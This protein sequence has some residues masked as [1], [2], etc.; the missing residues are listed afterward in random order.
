MEGKVCNKCGEWKPLEEYYNRKASKDGKASRCKKCQ[1]KDKIQYNKNN[2]EKVK[3]SKKRWK[4][5]NK[6]YQKQYRENNKEEIKKTKKQHYENNKNKIREM[7]K[8]YYESN[9]DK[10]KEKRKEY[11]KN[12]K[13]KEKERNKQYRI[14]NKYKIKEMYKQWYEGNKNENIKK[15]KPL[16]TEINPILKDLPV[17]GYIYK[18][19]NIKTGHVYIGQTIKPLDKRYGIEIVKSWIKERK[20]HERQK[21][22]DELIEDDFIVTEVLNTGIC[23]YHLDKLEAY[24][25]DKYDSY[26]NG[27][28]NQ[29]G[30][31][32][33]ND[34]IEEFIQLLED[35]NLLFVDGEIISA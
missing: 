19:E 11:Y 20:E 7:Q 22:L 4:E 12:N 34:G 30:N 1:N 26:N 21:F 6:G 15:I 8:Q 27:Y 33:N 18:F 23:K 9:K 25:I 13:D 31:Y 14:N 28:N 35:H 5:K 32:K 17:Y 2:P 24:Y 29:N 16:L 3:E 10:F